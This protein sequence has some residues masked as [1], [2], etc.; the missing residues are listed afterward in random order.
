MDVDEPNEEKQRKRNQKK[1]VVI[2]EDWTCKR[3]ERISRGEVYREM[4]TRKEIGNALDDPEKGNKNDPNDPKEFLKSLKG[5]GIRKGEVH[6]DDEL[7]KLALRIGADQV[8]A[9]MD[10]LR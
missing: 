3:C 1:E 7:H 10:S 2:P 9:N 5:L 8:M 6:D 4:D